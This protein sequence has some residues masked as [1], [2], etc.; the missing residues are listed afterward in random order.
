[1]SP[2]TL[3]HILTITLI[4]MVLAAAP[5]AAEPDTDYF[6][7]ITLFSEG[8]ITRFTEMPIHVYISP[9]LLESPYLPEIRYAMDEWESAAPEIIR[10]EETTKPE[11]ADIRVSWGHSSL[12]DIQDTRLGSAELTRGKT[13]HDFDAEIILMLEGDGTIGELTQE[14]MR[15]V[16]LHE[17]G[18][19]IGLWGHSPHPA[20]INYPT[21]TAQHPSAR[22]IATL[23]RLYKTPPDTP[24]HDIA[25][26]LLKEEI[27]RK[28]RAL[29]THYLLGTVYFDKAENGRI[30]L[31]E[32]DMAA[33]I[34]CFQTCRRLNPH[35]QP[36][37]EKLVQTYQKSGQVFEAIELLEK[38]IAQKPS[39]A[40]YN[41]LGIFYYGQKE[42]ERAMH[43]FENALEMAPH[44]KAARRNL[45]QL[46]REKAFSALG[47]RDFATATAAFE[48]ALRIKPLDAA[49]YHLM[50]NGYAQV[51][52]FEKAIG[53]YLKAR[54][55]NPVDALMQ[56]E[57]AQCYNNYGVALRNQKQWDAAISAYRNA[58]EVMPTFDIARTNLIDAFWQKGS[59]YREAGEVDAAIDVYREVVKLQPNDMQGHSL[60][61]E[62]YLKK[63]DAAAALSAFQKVYAAMPNAEWVKHNLV[64][65][66]HHYARSLIQQERYDAAIQH[67]TAAL[68]IVPK[69]LNLRLSLVHA[70]QGIGDYERAD[71]EL[72]RVLAQEPQNP[73]AK[74]EQM[75]L[76]IRRGNELIRQRNYAAALA[77]FTAIPEGDRDI[78]IDNTIAYLYLMQR[79]FLKALAGFEK[80]FQRDRLNMPAFR[81]L[82]SLESQIV[83]RFDKSK[84]D[85]LV[86]VRCA[87]AICL[88]HRKQLDAAREK[89][90]LALKGK[91]EH[92]HALLI[93]TGEALARRDARNREE[94]L[95]WIDALKR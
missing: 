69:E 12:M 85:T 40:D 95:R 91:Q 8:R 45:H 15:T 14:E 5:T 80:V 79:E 76:H 55:M 78:H 94:I 58:L 77:E 1:M 20:D 92:L 66:Y 17:F 38:R 6:N 64:A 67:L 42:N 71:A 59:A 32:E 56:R 62:L 30:R 74:A 46:L 39:P 61:G 88:M 75:N 26:K 48:K 11:Q 89:Y 18:H 28:P 7:H 35:F 31:P 34:A 73:Q 72:A 84:S 49:T 50:G 2:K 70:Y 37:I 19:A 86:R 36:A 9:I 41:T 47:D 10:F 13:A 68:R 3:T 29:R 51:G 43:A 93:E 63:G 27:A 23:R 65:A 81:N 44:H 57:L 90:A 4:A 21:A 25:I 52:E 87:V 22:D 83:R 24:Q 54:E 16:C 60:L 82:L 53:Y 33:A